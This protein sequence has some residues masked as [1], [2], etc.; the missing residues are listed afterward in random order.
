MTDFHHIY[1]E[2]AAAYDAMVA[3][4]DYQ[5]N[6][7]T[8]L[9]ALCPLD[10][11]NVVEMGAGTGRITLYAAPLVDRIMAFDLSPKMLAIARE[12][13]RAGGFDHALTVVADNAALP[14]KARTADVV[15]AG[16][17]LGHSCGWFPGEWR[18]VVGA[19]LSEM[20]RVLKPG[21]SVIIIE[22]LGTG[23]SAPQPPT[24]NLAAFYRLLE[25]VYGFRR[26]VVPTDYR[27]ES[28]E[29]AAERTRFFF[30]SELADRLLKDKRTILPEWTGVWHKQIP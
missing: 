11:L 7:W 2:E 29:A 26:S 13:L 3:C 8:T 25:S 4:E 28:P 1:A 6:L 19:A 17:S 22:T 9:H 5:G 27:F 30:G 24:E 10:G 20:E 18:D 15:I 23:T 21:G 16:W 14:V 12:K